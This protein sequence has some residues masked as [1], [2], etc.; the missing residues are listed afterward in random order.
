[1]GFAPTKEDL[2]RLKDNGYTGE[3]PKKLYKARPEGCNFCSKHG[4]RGQIA[5]GELLLVDE[6]VAQVIVNNASSYELEAVRKE[7]GWKSLRESALDKVLSGITSIQ[8]VERVLSVST[9]LLIAH[10]K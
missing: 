10:N 5:I 2:E 6:K 9:E 7:Q 1:M 8:E 4:F 3:L